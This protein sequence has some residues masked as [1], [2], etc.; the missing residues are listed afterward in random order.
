MATEMIL[1]PK[2]RYEQLA[3]DDNE[4]ANKLRYYTGLL[5]DNGVNF[6]DYGKDKNNKSTS[7]TNYMEKDV[8]ENNVDS[9]VEGSKEGDISTEQ[10]VAVNGGGKHLSP[11]TIIKDLSPNYRPYGQRLL[12]YIKKEDKDMLQ[13]NDQGHIILRGQPMAG[14]SVV[15]LVEYIFKGKGSKPKGT[16]EFRHILREM[17]VP[18]AI[19]KPLLLK[20]PGMPRDMKK[21][22]KKY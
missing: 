12:A 9:S 20:P 14:T 11:M 2:T 3:A 16:K 4:H 18:K 1:V 7:E 21:K 22:W 10:E 17:R 8:K 13:W 19:L 5:R 6:T 15:D